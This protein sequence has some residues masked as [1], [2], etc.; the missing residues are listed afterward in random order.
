ML[1]RSS[2]FTQY[3]RSDRPFILILILPFNFF[4]PFWAIKYFLKIFHDI[5]FFFQVF[6]GKIPKNIFE[7]ELIPVFEKCGQIWDL[8]LMMDPLTGQNRGY[9]FITYCNREA[10]QAAVKQVLILIFYWLASNHGPFLLLLTSDFHFYL[11]YLRS[12]YKKNL[13]LWENCI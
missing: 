3:L 8:R 9:A 7:D 13:K 5:F 11:V 10:A 4:S 12:K 1:Q 6:V 2:W